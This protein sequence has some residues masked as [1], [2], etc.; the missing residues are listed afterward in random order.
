MCIATHLLPMNR[1]FCVA[2]TC[3]DVH[4][5]Q[6]DAANEGF[7]QTQRQHCVCHVD[8]DNTTG[9]TIV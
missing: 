1:R 2:Q 7:T 5:R 9:T 6:H 4:A 3:V 8:E